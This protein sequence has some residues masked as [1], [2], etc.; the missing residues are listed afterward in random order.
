M[1]PITIRLTL[2]AAPEY[3]RLARLAA[4]DVGARVG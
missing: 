4:A 3:I 2:P 1:E